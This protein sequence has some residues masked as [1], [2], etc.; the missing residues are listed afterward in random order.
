VKFLLPPNKK[1]YFA[2]DLHLTMAPDEAS[3]N[4][5][6]DFVCWLD[7]I[8]NDAAA[9]FLLGDLFDFWFEYRHVVPRGF[10]RLLGKLA[11]LT[12]NGIPVHFFAG[13]HDQWILDYFANEMNI[14]VYRK[15]A[16]IEINGKLFLIGHGHG[17]DISPEGLINRVLCFAFGNRLL[18]R[19]IAM[20]HPRWIIPLGAQWS[21]N[22]RKRRGI[23]RPFY[24]IDCEPIYRYVKNVLAKKHYDFFIFGHRHLAMDVRLNENSR[25]INTGEWM[26]TQT[27][28]VFDGNDVCLKSARGEMKFLINSVEGDIV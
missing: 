12:D 11:E 20:L 28:A 6:Q 15:P 16:E 2:S 14:H 27:Y 1:I 24:N 4:R 10:V 8:K 21:E 5:E 23:I 17:N 7:T 19:M 3:R 22:H 26:E 25:Y 9:I 18:R 13:N